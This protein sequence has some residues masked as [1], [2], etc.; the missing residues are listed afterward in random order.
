MMVKI[1]RYSLKFEALTTLAYLSVLSLL[2]IL[3]VWQLHRSE[4]KREFLK[5]E[6]QRLASDSIDLSVIDASKPE[7][8]RYRKVTAK[9]TYDSNHQFLLDNQ[10]S[11]GK[12]GYLVLTPFLL[13]GQNKAVLINRGWI[14]SGVD[15]S[16]LPELKIGQEVT[17]ITGRINNFPSVGIKLAGAE[18][19]SDSW[20]SLVQVAN[21]AVLAKKLDYPLFE[22]QVE[23]DKELPDGFKREWHASTVMLPEQHIA[24]AIQWFLLALTLSIIFI[25]YSLKNDDEKSK[26]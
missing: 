19:P 9:G 10:I 20:P 12:A 5:L 23:L 15:R 1:G 21:S 11:D 2:I 24:Y 16:I 7:L 13:Q 3:G 26:K 14:A 25:W 17:S 8:L 4:Q 6:E 18:I 22:F